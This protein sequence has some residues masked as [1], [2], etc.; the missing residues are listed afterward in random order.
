VLPIYFGTGGGPT[1]TVPASLK[2]MFPLIT[3]LLKTKPEGSSHGA[4]SD[5]PPGAV[6]SALLVVWAMFVP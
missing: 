2:L 6:Y 5:H 4:I 1:V 3:R